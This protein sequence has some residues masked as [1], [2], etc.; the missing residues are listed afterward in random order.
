MGENGGCQFDER[1]GG[2][3]VIGWLFTGGI[4]SIVAVIVVFLVL[5]TIHEFGH[6]IVAKRAGVLVPRFAIG[7][8]PALM[9][10]GKGETEYS[11]RLFPIGGYVMLA[12][13][14]PQEQFFKIGEVLAV[15][16]NDAGEVWQI[17]DPE[18]LPQGL[19]GAL[20]AV[21]MRSDYTLSLELPDGIRSFSIARLAYLINGKDKIPLA[22]PDRQMGQ[23]PLLVRMAIVLAGPLM[24]MV[25]T[26]FLFAIVVGVIGT[27][28]N[29]PAIASVISDSP[30]ASAGIRAG[31]VLEAVNGQPMTTW[32]QFVLAIQ[33]HPD[34]SVRLTVQRSGKELTIPIRPE[35]D[36]QGVGFIGVSPATAHGPGMAI[37]GGLEETKTY[38]QLI[39]NALGTLF[40]HK[41]AFINDVGGPVKIVAVIGQQ[42]QVGLLNLVNLTAILSLNL[43]IF[44]LLPIPALDGSRFLFMLVEGIRGRPIDP[45]KEYMVHM[46]GFALLIL[47]T[48]FRTY[49]DVTQLF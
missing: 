36:S 38:T 45:R 10:F 40:T 42:A 32:T 48:V 46:V 44:N 18:S 14:M 20:R 15:T 16:L 25:L 29:P 4:K 5:V 33:G 8:G 37:T 47:F 24:N 3:L 9:R 23:K 34:R 2:T 26:V 49:L 31:D 22:P 7:F 28:K 35:K 19:Q 1:E 27:P 21:N 13:E 6:F 11:I 41:N 39:F 43:A 30:A 12:G 17:G